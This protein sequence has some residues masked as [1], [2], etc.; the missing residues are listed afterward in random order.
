MLVETEALM[1]GRR[2]EIVR[3]VAKGVDSRVATT[4][5]PLLI[6]KY[7][8]TRKYRSAAANTAA[9]TRQKKVAAAQAQNTDKL[10]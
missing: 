8:Q 4:K 3:N 9:K 5:D 2:Q 6:A 10:P 7:E 1:D